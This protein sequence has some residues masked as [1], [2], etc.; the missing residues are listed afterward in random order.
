MRLAVYLLV[1]V[2][3]MGSCSAQKR[4]NRI[5]QRNP[6]LILTDSIKVTSRILIPERS[7]LMSLPVKRIDNLKSGDTISSMVNNISLAI[8]RRN[9]SISFH[10]IV[11]ADTVEK[12]TMV[13]IDKIKVIR[14]D[15]KRWKRIDWI[16]FTI[17]FIGSVI[18][19][20]SFIRK[21]RRNNN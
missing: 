1:S 19:I 16:L 3:L 4:I 6:G 20:T 5:V 8:V 18:L 7:A 10:V 2:F 21:Q 17:I 14:S 9:D 13:R 11:P 15:K 12:D